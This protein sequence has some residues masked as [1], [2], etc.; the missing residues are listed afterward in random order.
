[1]A[2]EPTLGEVYWDT[3]GV[4]ARK[5]PYS[6][7]AG[8][9]REH[10]ERAA[11]AVGAAAI[12]RLQREEPHAAPGLA[13]A[14]AARDEYRDNAILH[15]RERDEAREQLAV[16]RGRAEGLRVSLDGLTDCA[17]AGG[18]I[19]E[20]EAAEYRKVIGPGET[21]REQLTGLR[22]R[23]GNLAAGLMLSAGSSAPSKKSE[24]EHGCAAA[25]RGILEG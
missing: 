19:T 23:F 24:I 20:D 21:L 14:M 11:A 17:L 3:W 18:I 8:E 13:A 10:T 12:A 5:I 16:L 1:M 25:I 2:G 9:Y 15:I 7:L 6:D 22:E 4:G